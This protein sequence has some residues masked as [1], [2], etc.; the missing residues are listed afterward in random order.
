MSLFGQV[1][2]GVASVWLPVR[3]LVTDGVGPG[4]FEEII[5]TSS[6]SSNC[7]LPSLVC[8]KLQCYT[9]SIEP[10]RVEH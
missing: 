6:L 8:Y 4:G 2:S 5:R 9:E 7:V 3:V 1:K 10:F